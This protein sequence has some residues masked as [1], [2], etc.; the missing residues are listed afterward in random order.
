MRPALLALIAPL[1]LACT[2]PPSQDTGWRLMEA[3]SAVNFVSVKSGEI[4][5]VHRFT[6]LRG[7]VGEDGLAELVVELASVETGI[8]IRNERMREHLFD[9]ATH[10]S[11]TARSTVD[12]DRLDSLLLG[13]RS[14]VT[15]DLI[16]TLNGAQL[17][18]DTPVVVTRIAED[19]VLVESAGPV[20][21]LA[22]DVGYTAGLETLR[23][24]ADLPSISPVVPVTVSLVF[25]RA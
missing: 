11:A 17:R 14:T 4:A 21:L 3:E 22:D 18:L 5:E 19:R 13:Q 2:P 20:V 7:T 15:L 12:I 6:G 23:E 10:A 1:L 8:D 24:L 16:V 25:E 9:V